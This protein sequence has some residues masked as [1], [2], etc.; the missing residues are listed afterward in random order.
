MGELRKLN[1][2]ES[3]EP[4]G[5][6]RLKEALESND[7]EG[8]DEHGG[9]IILDDLDEDDE[10][11]EG[12][13][14]FG[15]DPAELEEEMAGMKRAI[16]GGGLGMEEEDEDDADQDQEVEKLQ[17]MMLKMQAVRGK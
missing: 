7:W 1:I 3:L 17:A 12:S 13:V 15:I 10:E 2:D 16:Y 6:E 5:V 14:G 4:M 11:A 9:E 8:G